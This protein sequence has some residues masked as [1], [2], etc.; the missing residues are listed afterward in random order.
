MPGGVEVVE[1]VAHADAVDG[2]AGARRHA[3]GLRVVLVLL[4]GVALGDAGLLEGDGVGQPFRAGIAPDRNRAVVAVEVASAE[5]QVRLHLV[6]VGQ[7]AS[8]APLVVAPRG[9][10]VV[11]LGNATQQHLTVDG[12]GA[13]SSLAAWES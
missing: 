1:G 7:A 3:G 2:V 8:E 9:P 13:A 5:V 6:E 10:A 11:V 12:A 4:D